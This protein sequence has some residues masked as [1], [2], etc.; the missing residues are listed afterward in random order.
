MGIVYEK[1]RVLHVECDM[2]TSTFPLDDWNER[3][4]DIPKESGGL[5]VV[6]KLCKSCVDVYINLPEKRQCF[7]AGCDENIVAAKTL[8]RNLIDGLIK[9][10]KSIPDERA[11]PVVKKYMSKEELLNKP[12]EHLLTYAWKFGMRKSNIPKA[13]TY[14]SGMGI[15]VGDFLSTLKQSDVYY[16][17]GLGS[18]GLLGRISTFLK[19]EFDIDWSS[20]SDSGHI[21]FNVRWSNDDSRLEACASKLYNGKYLSKTKSLSLKDVNKM[22]GME[23]AKMYLQNFKDEFIED[24]RKRMT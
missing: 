17:E 1:P 14:L 16:I 13:R 15:S 5:S 9:H 19:K 12:I 10:K 6:G 2:C 8:P 22:G 18:W 23:A 7:K 11:K 24:V 21:S 20:H 3:K 4:D